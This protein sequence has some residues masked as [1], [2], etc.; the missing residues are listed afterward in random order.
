M[1]QPG[2]IVVGFD[3]SQGSRN[4]LV[5][6][7]HHAQRRGARLRII[8]C[9]ELPAMYT[10]SGVPAIPA[11]SSFEDLVR[12]GLDLNGTAIAHAESLDLGITVVGEAMVGSPIVDLTEQMEPGDELVV[13]ATSQPG[14]LTDVLGSVASGVAHRAK[15]PV[16]VV[17]GT[18]SSDAPIGTIVVGIDGS[19]PSAA[20]MEWAFAEARRC[21][22]TVQLVHGWHYPYV[23]AHAELGRD[24]MRD[25]L[26]EDATA[27]MN[28]VVTSLAESDRA[29]VVA[30][31]VVEGQPAE[32]V[33]EASKQADLVVVGSR[34]RGGFRALLLGSVSRPV[35]QH[36][37][38]PVAVIRHYPES[39]ER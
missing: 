4:A 37:L 32:V 7:A 18:V 1:T 25:A 10:M 31:K 24:E 6:A 28:R 34:G 11:T 36:S 39:E 23:D 22:A 16:I 8:T 2:T 19:P 14:V 35:L 3:G 21:G 12:H 33:V 17:H 38:C 9:T 20:A 26:R 5:W 30:T 15:G 29:L 27:A 13:A